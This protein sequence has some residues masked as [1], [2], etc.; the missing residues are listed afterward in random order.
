MKKL[1][2]VWLVCFGATGIALDSV[3]KEKK[4][5]IALTLATFQKQAGKKKG[6]HSYHKLPDQKYTLRVALERQNHVYLD[7][8]HIVSK[9][10]SWS[11]YTGK[12]KTYL[13]LYRRFG[14]NKDIEEKVG[15]IVVSGVLKPYQEFMFC[16]TTSANCSKTVRAT[17][18]CMRYL[19]FLRIVSALLKNNG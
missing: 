17:L 9:P 10:L 1:L 7:D 16:R 5:R 19:G 13:M 4:V 18:C 15:T 8:W 12:Y 6:E 2:L 14:K 11:R 3:P